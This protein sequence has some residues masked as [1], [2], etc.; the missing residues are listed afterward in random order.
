MN[1]LICAGERCY[2]CDDLSRFSQSF[3]V[4]HV[5]SKKMQSILHDTNLFLFLSKLALRILPLISTERLL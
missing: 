4:L 3:E 1:V 5:V 2:L